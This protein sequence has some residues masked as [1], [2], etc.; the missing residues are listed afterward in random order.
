MMPILQ[1]AQAAWRARAL[2]WVLARREIAARNAGSAGGW[3]WCYAQPLLTVAAYYLVFDV[4]FAMRLGDNAPTRA[5]GAFLVVGA[6]PWMAFCDTVSRAMNSLLDSGNLLQRSPLPAVLFPLRSALASTVI[7]AP[8]MLLLAVAYAPLHHFSLPVLALPA[9]LVLQLVLSL[10]L[11]Y[12]LAIFAAAMR[13]TLQVVGFAL[14]VGIFLSPVLFPI[15]MFPQAW[16]WL[17]WFNPMSAPVT[18]YQSILLQGQWPEPL[19]WGITLGWIALL[20]LALDRVV[21][22]SRDQLVDWL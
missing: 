19:V 14:S 9:L 12:L 6:L 16:R 20:T 7:Y 17:L 4:V 8:L 10:L 18:G 11:G 22:R 1:D 2:V 5:V 15:N 3:L 21:G 13:D